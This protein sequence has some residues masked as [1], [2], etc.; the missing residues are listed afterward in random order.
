MKQYYLDVYKNKNILI[1]GGLG[2]IG[3]TIANRLAGTAK[4]ITLVDSLIPQYGGNLFNI[5]A[6]QDKVNVNIADVR[7]EASMNV[8]VKNK[9]YLFNMAG[10]LSHIDSM[11]DPYTDLE[12]NCRSQLTI[13]EACR[14]N[15]RDIKIVLAGTRG[16]Y[17]RIEKT[18]VDESHPLLPTD[19]N[20]INK[21]AGGLYHLVYNNAY[22]IRSASIRLTNTYGPRHQMRHSKQGYLNWFLRLAMENKEIT[23]YDN[24]TA[25]RDFIY[26]DDAVEAFLRVCAS[27]DTNGQY[28]NL[29]SGRAVSI[30]ESA[31]AVI[32]VAGSGKI[33]HVEYPKDKKAI[34]IGDFIADY[35]KI[36]NTVGWEPETSFKD[37]LKKT[38]EFY[39]KYKEYYF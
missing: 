11:T 15:N 10:T 25:K 16:E 4:E 31:E 34:E 21:I 26:V 13:L 23:I 38:Y 20:G 6:I 33:K 28:Y 18:P 2:F 17:G 12:I 29:G 30:L 5:D 7:D 27:D 19:V 32:E 35:S 9:H 14:K 24:G 37:G 36:K 39:K 8:L 3:S 1:T 22:G